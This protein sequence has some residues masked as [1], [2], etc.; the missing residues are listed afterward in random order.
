MIALQRHTGTRDARL[1][2]DSRPKTGEGERDLGRCRLSRKDARRRTPLRKAN[3][4]V[5]LL[6]PG[7]VTLPNCEHLS[8]LISISARWEQKPQRD[9]ALFASGQLASGT[10]RRHTPWARQRRR[11]ERAGAS[12]T[13]APAASPSSAPPRRGEAGPD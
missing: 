3:S 10:A 1:G 7:A 11:R 13:T 2:R 4:D 5:A 6:D 8:I 12:G 9:R